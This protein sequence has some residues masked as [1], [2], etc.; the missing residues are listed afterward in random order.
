MSVWITTVHQFTVAYLQ[1][2]GYW[3]NQAR[4]RGLPGVGTQG[5]PTK[6]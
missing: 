4:I 5:T 6:N 2:Q 1:L 3:G